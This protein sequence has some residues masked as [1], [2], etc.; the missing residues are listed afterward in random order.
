MNEKRYICL[1]FFNQE[2][3]SG[4]HDPEDLIA[5]FMPK[6]FCT[7]RGHTADVLDVSWSKVSKVLC[8]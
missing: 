6:P 1:C 4:S 5:P 8:I 7:F 3:A 2:Q